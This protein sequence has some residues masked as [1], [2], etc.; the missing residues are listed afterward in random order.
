M[1]ESPLRSRQA[2]YGKTDAVSNHSQP[3]LV[4][5]ASKH[6][7]EHHGLVETIQVASSPLRKL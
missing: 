1:L 3:Q 5:G 6:I 7:L 2:V 4:D